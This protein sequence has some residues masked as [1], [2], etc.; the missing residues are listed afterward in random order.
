MVRVMKSFLLISKRGPSRRWGLGTAKGHL[1]GKDD[2]LCC[3]CTV[4]EYAWVCNENA[5]CRKECTKAWCDY[6]KPS[7]ATFRPSLRNFR[8]FFKPILVQFSWVQ[9]G[10]QTMKTITIDTAMNE[11][12]HLHSASWSNGAAVMCLIKLYFLGFYS[13]GTGFCTAEKSI[14]GCGLEPSWST[15]F[16]I[17]NSEV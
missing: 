2:Q 17:C 8:L 4:S 14:P 12:R 16:E 3:L 15:E 5:A 10:Y 6:W 13:S 7:Y 1:S 11:S 9:P